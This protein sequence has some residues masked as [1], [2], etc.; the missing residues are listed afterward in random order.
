MRVVCDV[1]VL[2]RDAVDGSS[3]S[4]Q[5]RRHQ[6]RDV[7]RPSTHN[8]TTSTAPGL[9]SCV[10]LCNRDS[11]SHDNAYGAVSCHD[12]TA[13]ARVHPVHLMNAAQRRA[14]ANLYD[15]IRYDILFA[16]KTDKLPV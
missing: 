9:C 13:V 16:L 6:S 2:G 11:N 14:A 7:P 8:S 12:G 10:C 3:T 1:T 4:M 5:H 15:M